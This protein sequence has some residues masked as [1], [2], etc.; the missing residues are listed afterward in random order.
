MSS[1]YN[2]VYPIDF[3]KTL[4]SYENGERLV[5]ADVLYGMSQI[6]KTSIDSIIKESMPVFLSMK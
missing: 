2:F 6:Y 5:R 3:H 1:C 4:A